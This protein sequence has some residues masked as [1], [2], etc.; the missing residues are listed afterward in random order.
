MIKLQMVAFDFVLVTI[1]ITLLNSSLHIEQL[2]QSKPPSTMAHGLVIPDDFMP[3][4]LTQSQKHRGPSS[5][6]PKFSPTPSPEN[7]K[8]QFDVDSS[9]YSENDTL[10]KMV[11]E[12]IMDKK[13]YDKNVVPSPQ[14][15][16]VEVDLFIQDITS[17]S[18]VTGSFVI[19]L[20]FSQMY[21][22]S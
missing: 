21:V 12:H 8:G 16:D 19:D 3:S 10:G 15:V 11:L 14:G 1:W 22:F 5:P 9:C 13:K 2:M 20:L 6:T 18:E 17:I 4:N 7:K